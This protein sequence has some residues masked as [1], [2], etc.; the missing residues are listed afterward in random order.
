VGRKIRVGSGVNEGRVSGHGKCGQKERATGKKKMRREEES[1][2]ILQEEDWAVTRGNLSLTGPVT[3]NESVAT[4]GRSTTKEEPDREREEN[5]RRNVDGALPT[6]N[7]PCPPT[8]GGQQAS[9][10]TNTVRTNLGSD[11]DTYHH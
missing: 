7:C 4:S 9:A 10:P 11:Q 8:R 6:A 5:D 1:G 2:E 3:K